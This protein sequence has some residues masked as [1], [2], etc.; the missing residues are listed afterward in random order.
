MEEI[1]QSRRTPALI[2]ELVVLWEKSVEVSHLFLST[3]EI[4]EIKKYVPQA[5]KE[6]KLMLSL[7]LRVTIV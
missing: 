3:E 6:I 1:S 7:N 4:S 2:E 5:L